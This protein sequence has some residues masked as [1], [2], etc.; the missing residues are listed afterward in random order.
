MTEIFLIVE[1]N[2]HIST[3]GEIIV[4]VNGDLVN[5]GTSATVSKGKIALQSEARKLSSLK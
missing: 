2:V 4:H 5:H 3:W 1:R